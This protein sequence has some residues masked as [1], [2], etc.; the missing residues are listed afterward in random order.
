M[1]KILVVDDELPIRESFALILG[2]KYK[3]LLA[4]SGEAALGYAA[5]QKLDLV[6]LDVRMPGLDGL[7]TLKRLKEIDPELEVVLVTAVNDVRKASEAIKYGARNYL[8][9]PFDVDAIVK[10]TE[11]LLRRRALQTEEANLQK[12][13][14]RRQVKLLGQ[15]DRIK[16]IFKLVKKVAPRDLRVLVLGEPGTEKAAVAELIHEESP[17]AALPFKSLALSAGQTATEIK[18]ALFG[19]EKG[20]TTADLQ[21]QTGLIE[22]ARG[23]TL[24]LDHLEHLPAGLLP[25]PGEARLIAGGAPDLAERSKENFEFFSEALIVLPPLRERPADLPLLINHY[26][27][28]YSEEYGK[29][30]SGAAPE[31]EELFTGHSWPGNTAELEALIRLL[32]LK[33]ETDRIQ[34]TDL[35][36][37]LLRQSAGAPGGDLFS[38]FEDEYKKRLLEETGGDRDKAAALLQIN[39]ALI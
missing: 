15:S 13:A 26:L 22:A 11:S 36:I 18:S 6:F 38:R 10:M 17:R 33:A 28:L 27:A 1:N 21:K 5:D 12:E 24:F 23:G 34:L 2:D 35:P 20:S 29:E 39:P 9:K 32:V 30:V 7:A 14:D 8:I 19:R 4:A 31:V 3:V 37:D 25:Q 16:E